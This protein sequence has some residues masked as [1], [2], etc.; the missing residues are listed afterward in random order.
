MDELEGP[1]GHGHHVS[2]G[3][4]EHQVAAIASDPMRRLVGVLALG[5]SPAVRNEPGFAVGL[6]QPNQ[7]DIR[8]LDMDASA[9]A[10]DLGLQSC[11]LDAPLVGDPVDASGGSLSLLRKFGLGLLRPR[12]KTLD[13]SGERVAGD[14]IVG[15]DN[16]FAGIEMSA[17]DGV[18]DEAREEF[19]VDHAR[20]TASA[21]G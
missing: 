21:R 14:G 12:P 7:L 4:R 9:E 19:S 2:V 10:G 17:H 1:H 3:A 13:G 6:R 8:R 18:S 11:R 20:L 5:L 16:V 15:L